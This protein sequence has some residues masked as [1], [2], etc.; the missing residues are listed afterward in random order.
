MIEI[1]VR[2]LIKDLAAGNCFFLRAPD[3]QKG[4]FI[5]ITREDAEN[6]PTADGAIDFNPVYIRID[7]YA[8]TYAGAKRLFGDI[9]TLLNGFMGDVQFTVSADGDAPEQD[10]KIHISSCNL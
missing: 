7:A 2:S 9:K 10:I 1:A 8:E 4:R 3:Q 6:W 5:I